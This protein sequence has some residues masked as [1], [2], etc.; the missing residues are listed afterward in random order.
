MTGGEDGDDGPPVLSAEEASG[1]IADETR[2][3]II[4]A[5]GEAHSEE[6]PGPALSWS[7][8]RER[9]APSMDSGRFNYHLDQLVG[10]FVNRT[11]G[12]YYLRR[13]GV[14]LYRPLAAAAVEGPPT[15]G[16]ESSGQPCYFCDGELVGACTDG[17]VE[18]RCGDCEHL[19]QAI[20]IPTGPV[21]GE[22]VPALLDRADRWHR[23]HL[24]AY[25]NG[26]C[27]HCAGPVS[28]E[29]Y[30]GED[31]SYDQLKPR[32]VLVYVACD[33]CPSR[34]YLPVGECVVYDGRLVSF[35]RRRGLDVLETPLWE[36][37]F[38]A[39][40]RGLTVERVD[41][42]RVTLDVRREGEKLRLTVEEPLEVVD[43]NVA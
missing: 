11:D 40:D 39:T 20:E 8:L 4:R 42:W 9:V 6:G 27:P 41:P 19:Y 31:V 14:Q 22:S 33:I 34:V 37:P 17:I 1:L 3:G 10:P 5:L 21:E 25:A 16:P 18:V 29:W 7:E 15:L 12:G 2:V 13:R 43:A 23:Q 26:G 24:L 28:T 38:A 36:L 32:A 35:C 30:R